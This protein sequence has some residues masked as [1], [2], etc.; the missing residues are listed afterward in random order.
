MSELSRRIAVRTVAGLALLFRTQEW[1]GVTFFPLFIS[2]Y[3]LLVLADGPNLTYIG[4]F[5]LILIFGLAC[6]SFAFVLNTFFDLDQD[7][8]AGKLYTNSG[9][10]ARRFIALLVA[11]S[12]V[13]LLVTALLARRNG[14]FWILGGSVYLLSVVYS[15]PPFRLKE[16]PILGPLTV[17][18][19][20]FAIPQFFVFALFNSI[21][22]TSVLF[23]ALFFV[24]GLRAMLFHQVLDYGNDLHAGVVTFVT[25]F[26]IERTWRVLNRSLV[27]LEFALLAGTL[28]VV[29]RDVSG[30][31]I[32]AAAAALLIW[33]C[34]RTVKSMAQ[35]APLSHTMLWEFYGFFWP[36]FLLAYGAYRNPVFFLLLLMHGSLSLSIWA[37]YRI[38]MRRVLD[39]LV[40]R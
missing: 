4:G 20:E 8:K 1:I 27:P 24:A 33:L 26:G 11:L 5:A 34:N 31:L 16:K 25:T 6:G 17:A 28:V 37:P 35:L 9:W 38:G 3:Y 13:S 40:R 14:W 10:S 29:D 36:M 39:R 19:S 30:M 32:F 22:W 15:A 23:G 2:F 12:A 21:S 18:L 7:G